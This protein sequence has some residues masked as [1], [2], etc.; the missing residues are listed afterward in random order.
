MLGPKIRFTSA[1]GF[2]ALTACVIYFPVLSLEAASKSTSLPVPYIS[3]QDIRA[4]YPPHRHI[5]NWDFPKV[6]QIPHREDLIERCN[7]DLRLSLEKNSDPFE[8]NR[9]LPPGKLRLMAITNNLRG[10]RRD[11]VPGHTQEDVP[12]RF[13]HAEFL[14]TPSPVGCGEWLRRPRR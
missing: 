2:F 11:L 6:S 12:P 3:W 5:G 8:M 10:I 9:A 14:D 7:Q 4:L 1:L 13:Y